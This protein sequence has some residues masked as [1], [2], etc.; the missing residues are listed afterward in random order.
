MLLRLY[1]SNLFSKHFHLGLDSLEFSCG[2]IFGNNLLFDEYLGISRSQINWGNLSKFYGLQ[3]N[4]SS[5]HPDYLGFKV[6]V[7]D[8]YGGNFAGQ[9]RGQFQAKL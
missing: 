6:N 4:L 8:N 7:V 3:E 2:D 5:L 9:L 1:L